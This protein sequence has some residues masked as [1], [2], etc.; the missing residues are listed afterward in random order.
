MAVQADVVVVEPRLGAAVVELSGEHD[1][2]TQR[3]LDDL[4]VKLIRGHDLVV[5]D[6]S[7]TTFVDSSFIYGLL[8]ANKEAA[9][10]GTTFRVQ[11]GT[12]SMVERVIEITHIGDDVEIVDNRADALARSEA[13]VGGQ[14]A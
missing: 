10:R 9:L 2:L 6:I 11:L 13:A 5:V 1:L 8:A 4:L 7:K 14:S 3:D 12:A